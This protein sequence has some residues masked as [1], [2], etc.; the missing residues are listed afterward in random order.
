MVQFTNFAKLNAMGAK[1]NFFKIWFFYQVANLTNYCS[2]K[3]YKAALKNELTI[4]FWKSL[5]YYSYSTKSWILWI[6]KSSKFQ[7]FYKQYLK[8][9]VKIQKLLWRRHLYWNKY[10]FFTSKVSVI[11]KKVKVSLRL[12]DIFERNRVFIFLCKSW[13]SPPTDCTFGQNW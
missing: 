10:S 4:S 2:L 3:N 6:F 12:F 11:G 9:E 13:G 5:S 8:L 7:H 1:I